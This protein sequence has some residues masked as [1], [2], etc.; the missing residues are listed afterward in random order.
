MYIIRDIFRTK[1]GKAKDLVGRFKKT[2][3]IMQK[4]GFQNPRVM[5][6]IVA[7][8][9]TVILEAEVDN[10]GT[11]EQHSRN[12]TSRPEVAEIMKGYMDLVDGGHREIFKV[13]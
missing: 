4:E 9:W 13:E 12:F 5:T 7:N 10:L 1:P 6:D 3:P 8:Y 2:I 11:F